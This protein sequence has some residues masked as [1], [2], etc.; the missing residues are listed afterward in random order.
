ASIVT[1]SAPHRGS[2]IVDYLLSRT[3]RLKELTVGLMDFLGR[4]SYA[5]EV[6]HTE[7]ALY[8]L[9]PDYVC[10]TFEAEHPIP[11]GIFCASYAGRAGKGTGIPIYPPLMI[12]NRILY[13]AA[14]VNDG[15]VPTESAKWG[16]VL[17]ILD[18]DHAKQIGFRLAPGA[19]DSKA[20][21]LGL[22]RD[23]ATRGL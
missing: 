20:F 14:G 6:P 8:E 1:V 10:G 21:F 9:S 11:E 17:G 2:P 19:F 5:A 3:D 7:E 22:A 15:L 13:E 16:E 23:L 18:A 12:P 4:A